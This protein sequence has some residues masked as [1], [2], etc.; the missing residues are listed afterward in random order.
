ME[1]RHC[2]ARWRPSQE[3]TEQWR[4]RPA[5]GASI[6]GPGRVGSSLWT[7]GRLSRCLRSMSCSSL[8]LSCSSSVSAAA[9]S[10]PPSSPSELLRAASAVSHSSPRPQSASSLCC[11]ARCCCCCCCCCCSP[12]LAC[13]AC[14]LAGCCRCDCW[15]RS[16]SRQTRHRL[17][18]KLFLLSLLPLVALL[19]TAAEEQQQPAHLIVGLCRLAV[20]EAQAGGDLQEKQH[21]SAA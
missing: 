14:A 12:L 10:T 17:L 21:R 15:L 20:R 6:A 13:S 8:A 5:E 9:T 1:L 18:C 16:V 2:S 11:A 19:V 7:A 4:Q 3:G